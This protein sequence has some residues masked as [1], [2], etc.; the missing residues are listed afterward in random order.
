MKK[1]CTQNREPKALPTREGLQKGKDLSPLQ[2]NKEKVDQLS[3]AFSYP[4]CLWKKE[5]PSSSQSRGH[6]TE[7]DRHRSKK[8]RA[9]EMWEGAGKGSGRGKDK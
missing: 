4:L 9:E 6:S 7:G 1:Q 3:T 8:G 5:I 2:Q